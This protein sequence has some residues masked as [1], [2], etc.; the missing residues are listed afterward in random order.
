MGCVL[1]MTEDDHRQALADSRKPASKSHRDEVRTALNRASSQTLLKILEDPKHRAYQSVSHLL[2]KAVG[3]KM[4]QAE[5]SKLP[6]AFALILRDHPDAMGVFQKAPA[7][8]GPG[9]TPVSH[10]YEI[11]GTAAL[12]LGAKPT[13][14]GRELHIATNDRVDFGMKLSKGY[15]QPRRFGTIEADQLIHRPGIMGKVFGID[16]KHSER[17]KRGVP[18]KGDFQRQ[19]DGIRTGFQDDKLHEF[20][21]VTNGVFAEDF[22]TMVMKENLRIAKD[23][24]KETNRLYFSGERGI[25]RTCLTEEEKKSIPPGRIDEKLFNEYNEEVKSFIGKYE[26]SQIDICEHVKYPGT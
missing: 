26:I 10:H 24:A 17:G 14:L 25:D 12:K 22:K 19:L 15:A 3:T 23:W 2:E 9:A 21:F 1:I 7:H 4:G 13:M 8:Y 5:R 6:E 20:Y 18:D 16:E 11:L